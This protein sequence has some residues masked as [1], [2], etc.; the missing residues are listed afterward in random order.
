MTFITCS[1]RSLGD[2]LAAA[3]A[4]LRTQVDELVGDLDDVQVV[5]DDQH[6]VAG[7]HQP[8]QHLDQLVHI[9]GVQADR[10]LVQ[11]VQRA[12]GGAAG[13]LLRAA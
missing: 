7:I 5:L 13:E 1:G 9:G 3:V 8:L 11:H 4:A 10:R 2:Q 6:R 12:P